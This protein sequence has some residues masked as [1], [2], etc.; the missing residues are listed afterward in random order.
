[1]LAVNIYS[2]LIDEYSRLNAGIS[3]NYNNNKCV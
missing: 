3:S 1:M 2:G